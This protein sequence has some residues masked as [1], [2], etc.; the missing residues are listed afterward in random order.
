M[1]SVSSPIGLRPAYHPSGVIRQRQILSIQQTVDFFQYQPVAISSGDTGTAGELIPAVS[2]AGAPTIDA[3]VLVGVFLG[4]EWTGT[5]GRRRLG[6]RWEAN[7]PIFTD[8]EITAYYT[9]DPEIVYEI[10]A[11]GSLDATSVGTQH[12][13]SG[14]GQPVTGLWQ[15]QLTVADEAVAG[16]LEIVGI[17]PAPDNI[18]G[19]AFTIVQVTLNTH[20][21]RAGRQY[22]DQTPV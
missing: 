11:A 4:V 6:N 2:V 10:Q 7:T 3:H 17:N 18:W 13:Y 5:D 20:R 9:R 14:T 1:S 8:T 12:Q 19:D 16:P 22:N 21:N 15:G